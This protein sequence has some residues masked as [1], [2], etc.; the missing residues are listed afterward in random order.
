MHRGKKHAYKPSRLHKQCVLAHCTRSVNSLLPQIVAHVNH[1]Q[2]K[3]ITEFIKHHVNLR[4]LIYWG[5]IRRQ[6]YRSSRMHNSIVC[7]LHKVH[8]HRHL[9]VH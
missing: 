1:Q 9:T 6:S 8:Q 7:A 4:G 3:H 5:H 2:I